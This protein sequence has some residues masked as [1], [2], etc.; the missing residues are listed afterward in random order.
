MK[1]FRDIAAEPAAAQ[2][3]AIAAVAHTG[4]LA[5][6]IGIVAGIAGWLLGAGA[7][8]RPDFLPTLP[9]EPLQAALIFAALGLLI[10]GI[11]GGVAYLADRTQEEETPPAPTTERS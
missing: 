7:V 4:P 6:L 3:A 8:P 10:G 5:F 1:S 2:H 11:I 9:A